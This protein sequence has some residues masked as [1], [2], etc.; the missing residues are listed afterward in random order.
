VEVLGIPLHAIT[1]DQAADHIVRFAAAGVGGWVVTPNLDILRRATKD[2]EFRRLYLQTTLRLADGMPLVW[3]SRLRRTP[4]PARAAGSDLI[5]TLAKRAAESGVSIFLLGGNP[6]AADK[7]AA[8]LTRLHPAL[9]IAGS[10]CPPLGFDANDRSI[11]EVVDRVAAADPGIVLV[12]LGCPKQEKLIEVMR[13]EGGLSR[14]WFLGIGI[15]FSFVA[16]DVRRAPMWM[17]RVGLEWSHRL[18]QEPRRLAGR[19]LI[20]GVPFALWLMAV[21]AFEGLCPRS[22]AP[23]RSIP[24]RS[25]PE[26]D[27]LSP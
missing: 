19:Y 15:T 7:T 20:D 5:F 10:M 8:E 26:K 27:G 17:R 11:R 24:E 25:R 12:A 18:L 14:A 6:G 21:S 1:I 16:G 13:G 2:A 9:R 3:A 22:A 23:R 4:L